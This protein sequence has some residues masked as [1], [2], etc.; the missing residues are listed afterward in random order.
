MSSEIILINEESNI[1]LYGIDFIGIIDRG[2]NIIELKPITLCNLKCKYCFVSAGDYETNFKVDSTYMVQKVKELIA[3]KGKKDIEIHI[4][5]YGEILLYSELDD[6]IKM[7]WKLKGVEI[8]SMQTNGL[9]LTEE[10]IKG[11]VEAKITRLNISLNTLDKKVA[12]YLC[13]TPNYDMGALT[14]NIELLL[15]SNIQLLLAP[16]W[17]PGKNDRDIEEIIMYVLKLREQGFNEKEIQIGIQKYLIYKTGRKLKKVRPKSWGYFYK[18]LTELERKYH[19]KLKLGPKDFNIHKRKQITSQILKKNDL[20]RVKIVSR[21]R[22]SRECIGKIDDNAGIKILLKK[23]TL[24]TNEL[25]GQ[26]IKARILKAN[27][28]DNILTASAVIGWD[29]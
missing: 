2:T 9:L 10:R 24:F 7:L 11:L 8:I 27:Y 19:L 15:N 20:I 26:K 18:Q 4:A 29:R 14:R 17:F 16:V 3:I 1:P 28:K 22:W 13:N 25:I 6:L 5:P 12:Q 23:P 21:G